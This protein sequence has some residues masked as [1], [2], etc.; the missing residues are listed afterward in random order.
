VPG[1]NV[2]NTRQHERR[3]KFTVGSFRSVLEP[4]VL[5]TGAQTSVRPSIVD[6]IR[7]RGNDFRQPGAVYA[8]TR[9][10]RR[11][12]RRRRRRRRRRA[13]SA[14]FPAE[15]PSQARFPACPG[16]SCTRRHSKPAGKRTGNRHGRRFTYREYIRIRDRTVTSAQ[17]AFIPRCHS[18]RENPRLTRVF[19][20]ARRQ[21][22]RE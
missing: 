10:P 14:H 22:H 6:D 19:R 7:R 21:L 18:L 9:A 2:P 11:R 8:P 17:L 13:A 12:C 3:K 4:S 16:L 5:R 15:F 20:S 1:E